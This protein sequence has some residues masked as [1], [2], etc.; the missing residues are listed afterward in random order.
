MWRSRSVR[1][2]GVIGGLL[3]VLGVVMT[4][5]PAAAI[6]G[7][8]RDDVHTN[9]GIVRF[10]T[11]SGRFRCSGTLIS[12][13]VVLTAGHCTGDTGTSPAT[14]VYVS[15]NTDLPLDPL[16]PGISPAESAA[17][18]ANYITGT[19]HPDPGWTGKLSISQQHD[20]GVVVLDAPATSKWPDITPAPLLPVGALDGNQGA[21]KN[22]T[23]TLVGY[24]VD[25][26]AKKTQVVVLERR[27]TTSFL[28]NVQDEVFTFQINDRDSKAGGGSCFG[29]SGGPAFLGPFVVGDSSFVNSLSCNAT[30]GYQRVDTPYARS[31]LEQFI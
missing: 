29:D 18:A 8:Q 11:D 13:T 19:A 21:L 9:V 2:G 12:P 6:V 5:Q 16:A 17:R 27:S 25:I 4:A 23:F 3:L 31:F 22:R 28:K 14:N 10:T 30:A 24:G 1:L 7:G 15:F 26:G 20:Q